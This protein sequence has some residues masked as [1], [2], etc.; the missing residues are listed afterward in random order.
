[1]NLIVVASGFLRNKT[2]N[3]ILI[4]IPNDDKH[5][6][7]NQILAK[8]FNTPFLESTNQNMYPK[9]LTK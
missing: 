6:S 3:D 5:N 4:Y 9:F 2:I 7:V 8:I 1:M